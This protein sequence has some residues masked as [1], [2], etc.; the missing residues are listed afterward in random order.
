MHQG[1]IV[2]QILDDCQ[3][4]FAE[5]V[6]MLSNAS[7]TAEVYTMF[8]DLQFTDDGKIVTFLAADGTHLHLQLDDVR[9]VKFLHTTNPQ[10]LPS[11]SVWFIDADQE[12]ALRVYLR[13]S[14]KE[15]TNQ[16]RHDLF[17]GLIE[18]YGESLPVAQAGRPAP[19]G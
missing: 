6:L 11:Y 13:K 4:G 1:N 5:V 19:E 15:E 2:R 12:P 9:E 7:A 10:G 16:P 8:E 17:M 3:P 14:E 18:K